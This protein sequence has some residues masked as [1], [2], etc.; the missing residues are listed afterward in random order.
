MSEQDDKSPP[1]QNSVPAD[2]S[3]ND[4]VPEL[5]SPFIQPRQLVSASQ[6][7]QSQKT[8]NGE[9]DCRLQPPLVVAKWDS[10]I[11]SEE[12]YPFRKAAR[13]LFSVSYTERSIKSLTFDLTL[14]LYCNLDLITIASGVINS[15]GP[16]L[17]ARTKLEIESGEIKDTLYTTPTNAR[18]SAACF[19]HSMRIGRNIP[20]SGKILNFGEASIGLPII[21]QAL[22]ASLYPQLV[23]DGYQATLRWCVWFELSAPVSCEFR[24]EGDG[25]VPEKRSGNL[26]ILRS[27]ERGSIYNPHVILESGEVDRNDR[28]YFKIAWKIAKIWYRQWE[29]PLPDG[30]G[31][32]SDTDLLGKP[33]Y[34]GNRWYVTRANVELIDGNQHKIAIPA[35]STFYLN[36]FVTKPYA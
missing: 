31:L 15:K 24:Y 14:K 27:W 28:L 8:K 6:L 13:N 20:S 1:Q 19:G 17:L 4:L 23:S 25:A 12:P 22:V 11:G 32:P 3:T 30:T 33:T 34:P 7:S 26:V 35:N 9:T 10:S 5:D 16:F 21:D 29:I 2:G 36:D 18:K